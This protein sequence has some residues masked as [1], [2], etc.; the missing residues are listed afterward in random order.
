MRILKSEGEVNILNLAKTAG[1]SIETLERFYLRR[2]PLSPEMARNLN[3]SR[4]S[5]Y[6]DLHATYTADRTNCAFLLFYSSH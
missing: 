5:L 4:T 3:R 6:Y 1:T 2:L